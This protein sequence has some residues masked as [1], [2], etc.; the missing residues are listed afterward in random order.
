MVERHYFTINLLSSINYTTSR[1]IVNQSKDS[2]DSKSAAATAATSAYSC[3]LYIGTI[4]TLQRHRICSINYELIH[5]RTHARAI[6]DNT[7]SGLYE[8]YESGVHAYVSKKLPHY[9][10]LYLRFKLYPFNFFFYF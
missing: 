5:R 10:I 8:K 7:P 6:C 1:S 9:F 4:A 2:D 3:T